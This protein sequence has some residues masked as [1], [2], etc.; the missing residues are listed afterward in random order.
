S[1]RR[2]GL[3]LLFAGQW[4]A[5]ALVVANL[6]SNGQ[7]V[8]AT[9]VGTVRD[10]GGGVIPQAALSATNANTGVVTR[11]TSDSAGNYVFT[12]LA[13]GVYTLTAEKTG[14]SAAVMSGI[15]LNVDQRASVDVVLQ[16]GQVTQKIEVQ[17]SAPL[18]DSTS[19]SL[20]TVVDQ[21]PIL[22]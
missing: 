10:A 19:A 16:V 7:Q 21:Q 8:S 14:F 12:T 5:L 4:L 18:V 11:T 15:S 9:L 3:R 17:E 13:P 2:Q 1:M 20:G 6:P 22:D